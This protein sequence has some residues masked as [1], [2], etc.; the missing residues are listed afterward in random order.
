[1]TKTDVVI[2]NR[3]MKQASGRMRR[4]AAR[5]SEPKVKQAWQHVAA[6]LLAKS[7]GGGK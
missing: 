4:I 5:R 6:M 3:V 1:M 7:K 2:L